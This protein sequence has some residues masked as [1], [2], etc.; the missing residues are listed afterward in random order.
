MRNNF[1]IK[2]VTIFVI[3][4]KVSANLDFQTK[5]SYEGNPLTYENAMIIFS[6]NDQARNQFEAHA[7]FDYRKLSSL[8]LRKSEILTKEHLE[9]ISA[10]IGAENLVTE[11]NNF[12]VTGFS[13][14]EKYLEKEIKNSFNNGTG[15]VEKLSLAWT[16][17]SPYTPIAT[18]LTGFFQAR[19]ENKAHDQQLTYLKQIDMK[20]DNLL[21]MQK[22]TLN[23]LNNL[24]S[25]IRV[26]VVEELVDRE[27]INIEAGI[28]RYYSGALGRKCLT[29]D[30]IFKLQENLN[31]ITEKEG[32]PTSYLKLIK[33]Y[34]F[35]MM[36][37]NSKEKQSLFRE[38]SLLMSNKIKKQVKVQRDN[39]NEKLNSLLMKLNQ[40]QNEIINFGDFSIQ[41]EVKR[42]HNFNEELKSLDDLKV[43]YTYPQ[44]KQEHMNVI[45]D[46]CSKRAQE[47]C[48]RFVDEK[49]TSDVEARCYEKESNSCEISSKSVYLEKLKNGNKT[50]FPHELK[51]EVKETKEL[52][53]RVNELHFFSEEFNK[54]NNFN[55][56]L[57][58][59]GKTCKKNNFNDEELFTKITKN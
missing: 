24:V 12:G 46:G 23:R 49:K 58:N 36:N 6:E 45:K 37:S 33:L 14:S 53:D 59:G 10:A 16:T 2:I 27:I 56:V 3:S 11:K 51:A 55:P 32:R 5:L 18:A 21:F 29:D 44:P 7:K 19:K 52:L 4:I 38:M 26:V 30:E 1:V 25:D 13:C 41:L 47:R 28:N 15:L 17:V 54:L 57:A 34:E 22:E 31:Y 40:S 48:L 35:G 9:L 20:L 8:G 50:D 43:A 42:T 39:G